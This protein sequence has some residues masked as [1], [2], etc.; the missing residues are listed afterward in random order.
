[1]IKSW[2]EVIKS[3]FI[4][5]TSPHSSFLPDTDPDLTR[6]A[7]WVAA[8]AAGLKPPGSP[9]CGSGPGRLS[10][11]WALRC[12]CAAAPR[13]RDASRWSWLAKRR[14]LRPA[15]APAPAGARTAS[16][17]RS[18]SAAAPLTHK[19]ERKTA[20][21]R[22]RGPIRSKPCPHRTQS[23]E[24]KFATG[25]RSLWKK[26]FH[27]LGVKETCI[28]EHI[29]ATTNPVCTELTLPQKTLTVE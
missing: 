2:Q 3:T 16:C 22:E 10:W 5:P 15:P 24:E 9:S 27:L 18:G 13:G 25:E 21:R 8:A 29:P 14:P 4:F 6:S 17:S 20:R 12:T 7:S 26:F 28:P 1:M 19:P 23:K 11:L